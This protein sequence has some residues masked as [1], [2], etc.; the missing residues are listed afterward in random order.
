MSSLDREL[1]ILGV[2]AALGTALGCMLGQQRTDEGKRLPV[3]TSGM[4]KTKGDRRAPQY[5]A[6]SVSTPPP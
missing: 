1:T 5:H 4:A 2:G 6:V 3:A